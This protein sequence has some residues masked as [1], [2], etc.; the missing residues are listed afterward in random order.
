MKKYEKSIENIRKDL[1]KIYDIERLYRKFVLNQTEPI[2]IYSLYNSLTIIQNI[3]NV[4]LKDKGFNTYFKYK[5]KIYP[6][7]N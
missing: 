6:Q 7:K 2:D 3:H 1:N 5:I 4:L